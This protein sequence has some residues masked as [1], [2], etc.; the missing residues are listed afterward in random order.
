LSSKYHETRGAKEGWA[1]YKNQPGYEV[2]AFFVASGSGALKL[3]PAPSPLKTRPDEPRRARFTRHVQ[4][5]TCLSGVDGVDESDGVD[6]APPGAVDDPDPL[7]ALVEV[8]PADQAPCLGGQRR[9]QRDEVRALEQLRPGCAQDGRTRRFLCTRLSPTNR[10]LL[11]AEGAGG[12]MC[13]THLASSHPQPAPRHQLRC[14]VS[15]TANYR[16]F[17]VCTPCTTTLRECQRTRTSAHSFLHLWTSYH[18]TTERPKLKS[19][20]TQL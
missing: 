13:G 8:G 19:V 18:T 20:S 16:V 14:K 9:V 4:E 6:D 17:C 5:E 11:A 2:E 10:P 7:L 3:T 1:L 12:R 15:Q